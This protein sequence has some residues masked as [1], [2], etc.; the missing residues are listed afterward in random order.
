MVSART[1]G[2]TFGACGYTCAV[3]T[4]F[5]TIY[6]AATLGGGAC[7]GGAEPRSPSLDAL[8]LPPGER[9]EGLLAKTELAVHLPLHSSPPLGDSVDSAARAQSPP[10]SVAD[11][12]HIAAA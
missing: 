5:A 12:E 7:L 4:A 2:W 10:E 8:Q 1:V 6:A 11:R 3:T 9:A